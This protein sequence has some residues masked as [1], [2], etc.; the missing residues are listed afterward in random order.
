MSRAEKDR[1][2]F[3]IVDNLQC[4]S[5]FRRMVVLN[6]DSPAPIFKII[7][8]QTFNSRFSLSGFFASRERCLSLIMMIFPT[9]VVYLVTAQ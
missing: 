1:L 2:Y 9:I 7:K 6:K 3:Q 4:T 5:V 8:G